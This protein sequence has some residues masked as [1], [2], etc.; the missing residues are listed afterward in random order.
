MRHDISEPLV[1]VSTGGYA[2]RE[3]PR[4]CKL[5]RLEV[6]PKHLRGSHAWPAHRDTMLH[7][8]RRGERN[9]GCVASIELR[10]R[11]LGSAT[12]HISSIASATN[13]AY[14]TRRRLKAR[15]SLTRFFTHSSARLPEYQC[16]SY[17]RKS[18]AML[19]LIHMT[20]EMVPHEA[21]H[22]VS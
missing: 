16:Q 5:L 22:D 14:R 2:G 7:R 12:T 17:I 3:P 10:G 11:V 13:Q 8:Q 15:Q 19:R 1:L 9:I 6:D 4:F 18:V 20:P 21:E